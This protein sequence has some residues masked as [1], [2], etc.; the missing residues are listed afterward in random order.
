LVG[1]AYEE[2]GIGGTVCAATPGKRRREAR[3]SLPE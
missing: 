1:Q 2:E 3:A